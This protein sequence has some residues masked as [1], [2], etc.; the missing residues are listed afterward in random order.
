MRTSSSLLRSSLSSVTK[1]GQHR[2]TFIS[3]SFQKSTN[4]LLCPPKK[5]LTPAE[6]AFFSRLGLRDISREAFRSALSHPKLTLSI[7]RKE[8]F[9]KYK[10][11][12]T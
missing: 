8:A 3:E 7:S 12:G 6:V 9:E 4:N 2:N 1:L 10:N 11:L 5:C